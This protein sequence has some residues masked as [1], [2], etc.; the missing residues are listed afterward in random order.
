MRA[1]QKNRRGFVKVHALADTQTMKIPALSVTDDSVGDSAM[2]KALLGQYVSTKKSSH[3][4]TRNHSKT[5]ESPQAEAT[6]SQLYKNRLA[7]GISLL[8]S[9]LSGSGDQDTSDLMFGDA[10]YISRENVAAC[11]QAGM[12]SS[13]LHRNDVTARGKGSGDAWCVSV[14]GGWE[15][16]PTRNDS[17]L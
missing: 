16:V 2:L 1:K 15:K 14:R 10:A 17:I 9:L 3:S 7:S 11:K 8:A 13:I 4:E 5:A 6:G 12:M